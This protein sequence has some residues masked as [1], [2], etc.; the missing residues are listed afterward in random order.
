MLFYYARLSLSVRSIGIVLYAISLTRVMWTASGIWKLIILTIHTVAA[1]DRVA[2]TGC[3]QTAA[4]TGTRP[5]LGRIETRLPAYQGNSNTLACHCYC[6]KE[7]HTLDS[8]I[9]K[10][11]S[12]KLYSGKFNDRC[13]WNKCTNLSATSAPQFSTRCGG[14]ESIGWLKTRTW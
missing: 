9:V 8:I 11:L 3:I 2:P 1:Y 6:S 13:S 14:D 5:V 10:L 12:A 7:G 4:Y